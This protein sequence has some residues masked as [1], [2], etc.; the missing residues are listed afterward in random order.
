MNRIRVVAFVEAASITGPAGNLLRFGGIARQK[1][2]VDLSVAAFHR[3][4]SESANSF[5]DAV[6]NAGIELDIIREKADASI[7][8][9]S[10]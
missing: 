2:E 8:A 1:G 5:F 7:A 6:R 10:Q 9:L 4:G 3:S